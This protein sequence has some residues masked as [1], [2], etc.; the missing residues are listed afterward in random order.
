MDSEKSD[1]PGSAPA[2]ISDNGVHT[3]PKRTL[4]GQAHEEET[5]MMGI[6]FKTKKEAKAAVPFGKER[7][8]ETSLFGQEYRDGEH[9]VCISLDPYTTR[10]TF[11]TITVEGGIVVK[12]V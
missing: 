9:A 5:D 7:I 10:N 3:H 2:D 6:R 11:G 4:P 8:I 12:V 1:N